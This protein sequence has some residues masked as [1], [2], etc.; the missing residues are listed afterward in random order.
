M[1]D[2]HGTRTA[3]W[4][5]TTPDD[6]DAWD[7]WLPRIEAARHP[8]LARVVA[9]SRDATS[10]SLTLLDPDS[11]AVTA[12]AAR[13]QASVPE[14]LSILRAAAAA[15]DSLHAGTARTPGVAHGAVSPDAVRV[16]PDS[17]TRV[18]GY[19][20]WVGTTGAPERF[21]AP[22]LAA[23]AAATTAGDAYAFA[24]TVAE[25]LG[26]PAVADAHD[27]NDVV[28]ALRSSPD[29]RRRTRLVK[30][31]HAALA[32][33]PEARP[34]ALTAWLIAAVEGTAATEVTSPTAA[35][36]DVPT[37]AHRSAARPALV[38]I[39]VVLVAA[40]AAWGWIGRD[41]APTRA[42]GRT[43]T[44]TG[45][46]RPTGPLGVKAAWTAPC[47]PDTGIA[48]TSVLEDLQ[49]P[50]TAGALDKAPPAAGVGRWHTG[51]L[52]LTL[53]GRSDEDP[54]TVTE[55]DLEQVGTTPTPAWVALPGRC[56]AAADPSQLRY[57]ADLDRRKLRIVDHGSAADFDPSGQFNL[58]TTPVVVGIDV[59]A[60]KAG[61]AWRPVIHYFVGTH[62]GKVSP[63]TFYTYGPVGRAN[64]YRLGTGRSTP[65][66][67]FGPQPSASGCAAD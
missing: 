2:E 44:P 60:C 42:S 37:D 30:A 50:T 58:R 12:W 41:T 45:Q 22:E 14:R 19:S 24:R 11:E 40:V 49:H 8:S 34:H 64:V 38:L 29:T 57:A 48:A 6:A 55:I 54:V 46:A 7:A 5:L 21:L 1:P 66:L 10:A 31:V 56:D 67:Q 61:Y 20:P 63:G 25:V 23:G 62:Q 33:P 16:A 35:E 36:P 39:A 53:V 4:P 27:P 13:T 9:G 32:S 15:L 17:S 26:G 18:V 52:L 3:V 47:G 28:R 43:P 65:T 51:R 59:T